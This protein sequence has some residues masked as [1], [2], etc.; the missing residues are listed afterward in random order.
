MRPSAHRVRVRVRVRGVLP[1]NLNLPPRPRAWSSLFEKKKA[2][3]IKN[4]V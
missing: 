1:P 3:K 4:L 2:W